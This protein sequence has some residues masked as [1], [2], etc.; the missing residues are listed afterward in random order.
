MKFF[1]NQNWN[2]GFCEIAAKAL[3]REKKLPKI[4]WMKHPYHDRWFADP[5]I[6]SVDEDEI[7]VFVEECSIDNPK[8]VICELVL[9]R[10]T[11]RLKER[12]LLLEISKELWYRGKYHQTLVAC[13]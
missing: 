3:V 5:Y 1:Y 8:G 7:V 11:K 12:Y 13:F 6:L 2:I 10:V 4:Q 9:D